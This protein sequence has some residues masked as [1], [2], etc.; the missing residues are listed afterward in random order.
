MLQIQMAFKVTMRQA[1]M[2][3]RHS[4]PTAITKTRFDPIPTELQN[5]VFGV[6]TLVESRCPDTI[7]LTIRM[8]PVGRITVA[9]ES[10]DGSGAGAIQTERHIIS[11]W[12]AGCNSTVPP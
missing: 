7:I 2:D 9:H 11:S 8:R 3:W 6:R 4:A 12:T 10:K 5:I 1:R